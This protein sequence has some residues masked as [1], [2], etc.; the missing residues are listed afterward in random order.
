[1]LDNLS[2]PLEYKKAKNII[3]SL[4][5]NKR[6][7]TK[8]NCKNDISELHLPGIDHAILYTEK[9]TQTYHTKGF[10]A[11]LG[12]QYIHAGCSEMLR[13]YRRNEQYNLLISELNN[14]VKSAPGN[15][16]AL[17]I[18]AEVY[19]RQGEYAKALDDCLKAIQKNEKYAFAYMTRGECA[20]LMNNYDFALSDLSIAI[21]LEPKY[22]WNY[23]LRA[24][25]YNA[26]NKKDKA[27][28]DYEYAVKL[29]KTLAWVLNEIA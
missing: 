21:R 14:L 2:N 11:Y 25:V 29:E 20:F 9:A 7:L 17:A 12:E 4:V 5:G 23:I 6:I 27:K 15:Y 13:N 28:A 10:D 1:M 16:Q 18:R 26:L 24:R 8:K 22:A 19:L 3:E